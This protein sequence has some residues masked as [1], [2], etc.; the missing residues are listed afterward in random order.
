M[1]KAELVER[2]FTS[3]GRTNERGNLVLNELAG[4]ARYV[5]DEALL[6]DGWEQYDTEDDA[7]YFGVWVH[8]ADRSIF[9]FAEGDILLVVCRT[10]EAFEA[11][12][13]HMAAF[14]GKPPPAFTVVDPEKRT[15]TKHIFE[16]PGGNR[17]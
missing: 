11:E 3:K 14:Y 15:I 2:I 9:T 8:L 10:D 7:S 5:W 12:L 13:D 17:E 6:R 1:R 16:R 4:G